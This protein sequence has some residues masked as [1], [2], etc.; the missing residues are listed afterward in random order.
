MEP[1]L[2]PK[3]VV[4]TTRYKVTLPKLH[5]AQQEVAKSQARV[6]CLVAG[7]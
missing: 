1:S 7:R 2:D 6:K 5:E 3:G 4:T